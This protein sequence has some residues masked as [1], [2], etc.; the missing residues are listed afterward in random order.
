MNMDLSIHV[1][2]SSSVGDR[3][4]K[5]GIPFA[6]RPICP[7]HLNLWLH[8]RRK[9]LRVHTANDIYSNDVLVVF[10]SEI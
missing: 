5:T 1:G 7:G 2:D 6:L 4:G 9:I 3:D 10:R 8:E